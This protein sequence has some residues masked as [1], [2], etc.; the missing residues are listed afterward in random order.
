MELIKGNG[1]SRCD[2]LHC[3]ALI[4][5]NDYRFRAVEGDYCIGCGKVKQLHDQSIK[6]VREIKCRI[7]LETP[8]KVKHVASACHQTVRMNTGRSSYAMLGAQG[9]LQ[10]SVVII[11]LC[12]LVA[13]A[14]TL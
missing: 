9:V 10:L 8:Q 3:N 1:R 13:I 6:Y 2:C 14:M 5:S 11:S 7:N 4:S 12:M